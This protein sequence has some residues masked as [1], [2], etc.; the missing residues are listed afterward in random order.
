MR[1]NMKKTIKHIENILKNTMKKNQEQ[2]TRV[3]MK[4][5]LCKVNFFSEDE[6]KEKLRPSKPLPIPSSR[7]EA[8]EVDN[9]IL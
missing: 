1:I 2:V 3:C 5:K 6:K 7:L 4:S 9:K 8:T